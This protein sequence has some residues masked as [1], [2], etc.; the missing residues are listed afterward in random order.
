MAKGIKGQAGTQEEA[1][2]HEASVTRCAEVMAMLLRIL[3]ATYSIA[4]HSRYSLFQGYSDVVSIQNAYKFNTTN[5]QMFG[6]VIEI[7]N[8]H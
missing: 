3:A 7:P 8:L 5:V 4:Q 1:E 6:V 2:T